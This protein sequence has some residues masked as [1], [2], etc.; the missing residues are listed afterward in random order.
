MRCHCGA[1][2]NKEGS[3]VRTY[4][5]KS[6][7]EPYPVIGRYSAP[8]YIKGENEAFGDF[9]GDLNRANVDLCDDNDVCAHCNE[10]IED[11]FSV[12][13]KNGVELRCPKCDHYFWLDDSIDVLSKE[14]V[15]QC[16]GCDYKTTIHT[17]DLEKLF[18][19]KTKELLPSDELLKKYRLCLEYIA[20]NSDTTSL[21]SN[22][23]KIVIDEELENLKSPAEKR[24]KAFEQLEEGQ[25]FLLIDGEYRSLKIKGDVDGYTDVTTGVWDNTL[26][27]ADLENPCILEPV[28]KNTQESIERF[29]DGIVK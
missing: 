19:E 16:S 11:T 25:Y 21:V 2:L 6:T 4:I 13:T 14:N 7:G 17:K 28:D 9:E 12:A 8:S 10:P 3:V 26:W 29:L 5:L 23:V 22:G 24:L 20:S 27:L 15:H 18:G 1:D